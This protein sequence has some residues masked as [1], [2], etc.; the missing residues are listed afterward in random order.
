MNKESEKYGCLVGLG[1]GLT[2]SGDD[3]LTGLLLAR[4]LLERPS[5]APLKEAIRARLA[6]TTNAGK[7]LLYGAL[8]KRYPFYLHEFAR[9]WSSAQDSGEE[10]AAVISALAHGSTSGT[11][12]LAGLVFALD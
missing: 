2:P 11:D 6:L 4:D 5:P 7:T 12:A 1:P 3:F 10:A 9:A 8:E